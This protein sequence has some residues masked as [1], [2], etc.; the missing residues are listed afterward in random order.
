MLEIFI[1][2]VISYILGN[3]KIKGISF[4]SSAIILISMIFGHFG[5][6]MNPDLKNLGLLMFVCSVGLSSGP[7]FIYH[8]KKNA[9]GYILNG[10]M[11]VFIAFLVTALTILLFK[12]D[13]R[14]ALGLFTGALTSTPGFAVASELSGSSMT[15]AAYGISYPFGVVCVTLFCQLMSKKIEENR[16]EAPD[17]IIEKVEHDLK[18][19]DASGILNF[20]LTMVL[21]IIIAKIK[22]PL[23]GG[24]SFSFGSA[25]GPLIA[26]LIISGIGK[27]NNYTLNVNNNVLKVLKDLGLSFFLLGSGLEAGK[28]IVGI[29]NEYGILLFI[30]GAFI[31][32]L[33]MFTSYFVAIKLLKLPLVNALGSICGGMTS[34]PALGS[35]TSNV[36]DER[37]VYSYAATYPIALICVILFCQLLNLLFH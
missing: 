19:F 32:A 18:I 33:P 11:I 14:L 1:I 15:T 23:P 28:D 24:F 9:K 6:T 17:K 25:G 2:L 27:I 7:T 8:F 4:G 16:Q 36:N 13:I 20:S 35:L 29:V 34:T 3:I 31:T 26:G 21:G 5:F 37:I 30:F 22:I 10:F 12:L